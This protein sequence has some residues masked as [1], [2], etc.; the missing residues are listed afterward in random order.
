MT[1]LVKKKSD[2]VI[3]AVVF[4][5]TALLVGQGRVKQPVR[6]AKPPA[7]DQGTASNYFFAD[8]FSKDGPLVG[9][10]PANP[11]A[12][13]V[14]ETPK[15]PGSQQS[16]S[17]NDDPVLGY[18]WSKVVSSV[19][20]EDEVKAIKALVDVDVQRPGAFKGRG[21]LKCRT[22][23]SE[24]AMLFAIIGEY[25]AEVRWKEQ[26]PAA[27]DGFAR[28][29]ANCKVGSTQAFNDARLRKEELAD[30]IGGQKI[31]GKA[32]ERK[33]NWQNVCDRAPL[34]QRLEIGVRERLAEWTSSESVF[35]KQLPRALHEAELTATIAVVLSQEGMEDSG[36]EEYDAFAERMK[37]AALEIVDGVKLKNYNQAR[38][39]IGAI[40]KACDECHESY[41]A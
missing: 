36:D 1:K 14:V 21:Y 7:F 40:N 12:I 38:Q 5:A 35:K 32:G 8:V 28:T 37:E 29:A 10:R 15:N 9:E 18:L 39:A 33:A 6:R 23:F 16:S 4:S 34:M 26:G 13:Q 31:S 20:I 2:I 27:R 22:H 30:L 17:S 11:N 3:L 24:L 41:R 25:D 19:T